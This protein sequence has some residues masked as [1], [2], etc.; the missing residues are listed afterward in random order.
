MRLGVGEW[1][2]N[3]GRV[4]Y[5]LV[6]VDRALERSAASE[7]VRI[8]E[9]NSRAALSYYANLTERLTEL[10]VAKGVLTPEEVEGLREAARLELGVARHELW[11][12]PDV[13]LL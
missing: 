8:D 7:L 10:L 4:K 6:L 3:D 2:E 12:V 9:E 1:S 13:D 5:R 11:R